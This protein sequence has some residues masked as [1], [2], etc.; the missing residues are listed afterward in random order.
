MLF[1][2]QTSLINKWAGTP[3]VF[4]PFELKIGK[5][6]YVARTM[7]LVES[8]NLVVGLLLINQMEI[9]LLKEAVLFI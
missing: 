7:A 2:L 6:L 5:D 8:L 9:L 1:E 3:Y 4:C